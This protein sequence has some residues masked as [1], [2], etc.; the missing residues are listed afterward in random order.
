MSFSPRFSHPLL[1][2]P[3]P[4]LLPDANPP[5]LVEPYLHHPQDTVLIPPSPLPRYAYIRT[6]FP[7]LLLRPHRALPAT[8]NLSLSPGSYQRTPAALLQRCLRLR[9]KEHTETRNRIGFDIFVSAK[10]RFGRI[11]A[12]TAGEEVQFA[13]S[14][15]DVSLPSVNFRS[16]PSLI[17]KSSVYLQRELRKLLYI[18]YT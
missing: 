2:L 17:L 8:G 10:R 18:V 16:S 3:P 9:Y 6:L 5:T 12:V 13:S 4:F 1:F 14:R 11:L 15:F 7:V